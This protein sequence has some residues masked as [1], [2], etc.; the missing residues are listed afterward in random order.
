M[1]IRVATEADVQA[2]R[3]VHE[4][5]IRGLGSETY[6]VEQVDAWAAGVE[7][8]DYAAVSHDGFY[9][10]VA[11]IETGAVDGQ[12]VVGFGTL[13]WCE[14]DGYQ[15]DVDAE[16]TAVYVH[17]DVAR[18]GVGTALLVDLERQGRSEGFRS[19]GLTASTNAVPFY[20]AHGYVRVRERTHEFSVREGTGV[21]GTVVEMRKGLD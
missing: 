3:T 1:Q 4:A 17:P 14:P 5:S 18:D 20:E 12:S 11:E 9:Y 21:E 8:A 13:A 6:D 16:V 10:T 15:A 19:L 2:I 7:S